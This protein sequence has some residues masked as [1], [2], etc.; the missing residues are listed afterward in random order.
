MSTVLSVGL[1]SRYLLEW[2]Q[3]ASMMGVTSGYIWCM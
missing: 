3:W 2:Y 1:T